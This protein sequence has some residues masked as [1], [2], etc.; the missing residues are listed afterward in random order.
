MFYRRGSVLANSLA[1]YSYLNNASQ[2]AF[3]NNELELTLES[4]F[5]NL[6]N[7]KNITQ[8]LGNVTIELVEIIPQPTKILSK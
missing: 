7:Y 3:L 1:E 4:I 8:A 2:I 6:T 5:N